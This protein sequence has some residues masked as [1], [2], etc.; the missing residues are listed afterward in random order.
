M[1]YAIQSCLCRPFPQNNEPY[2]V[3]TTKLLEAVQTTD[4]TYKEGNIEC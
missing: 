1:F 4:T 2:R 3:L